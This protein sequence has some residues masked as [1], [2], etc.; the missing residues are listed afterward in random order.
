[1]I[2]TKVTQTNIR[3]KGTRVGKGQKRNMVTAAL[4]PHTSV[5]RQCK[6]GTASEDYIS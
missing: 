1:M 2:K 5:H 6:K 3:K 4:P